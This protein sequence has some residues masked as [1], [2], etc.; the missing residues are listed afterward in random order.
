VSAQRAAAAAPVVGEVVYLYGTAGGTTEGDDATNPP[1]PYHDA[2]C[3][4]DGHCTY[5]RNDLLGRGHQSA[6]T[7]PRQRYC[8]DDCR[9]RMARERALDRQMQAAWG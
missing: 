1:H 6:R 7:N 8:S 5:C 4:C 3:G 2:S 9:S